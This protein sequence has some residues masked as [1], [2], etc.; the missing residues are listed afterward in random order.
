[1]ALADVFVNYTSFL[2][3]CSLREGV[4]KNILVADWSVNQNRFYKRK[5]CRMFGNR[6]NAKIC[7]KIFAGYPLK[8]LPDIS[9]K[10][11]IF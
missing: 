6:K 8:N 1:M 10:F 4:I 2:L 7:C 3:T 11:K 5:R 9:V